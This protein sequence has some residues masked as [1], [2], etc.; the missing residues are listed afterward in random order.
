MDLNLPRGMR[1]FPPEEKIVR[2]RLT[3]QL[4]RVFELY[5]FVPL[6]TPV[7][8]R[9]DVL[10]AKYAGG[11]DSDVMKEVFKVSDQ[12]GRELGLRFDLTVPLARFVAMNPELKM[13]FKRYQIGKVYRDG[14]I[15]FGRY[16]EFW[17]YDVDIVGVKS[18]TADAEIVSLALEVFS[19]LGLDVVLKVNN[20]KLLTG[21]LLKAGVPDDLL[22]SAIIS[23]DKL[24]KI[25]VEGVS[26]ELT[27]K[28][29]SSEVVSSLISFLSPGNDLSFFES[30][31]PGNE[32]LLEL[33]E[34]FSLLPS[35]DRVV[36][37]PNLARGLAYY[38][39][40][41]FEV[42]LRDG[43]FSSSLAGGGRYDKMIG[44]YLDNK[45]EVPAVG[46]SFGFE[47]ILDLLKKLGKV[48]LDSSVTRVLLV[49]VG[50]FFKEA[51]S[52]TNDLRRAGVPS[53]VDLLGRGVSKN[54][55]YASAKN[56]PFV[57]FVGEDE[58]S[59][60]LFTLKELS[61][62]VEEK[63]SFEAVKKKLLNK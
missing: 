12:G 41:V 48:V 13:P 36:F 3:N 8:E 33:K 24:D 27:A 21:V 17:Q 6:E 26:E 14:P 32:G 4:I 2:Q 55:K 1:D 7:V 5:G 11:V 51:F 53:E 54:I 62:G 46:L 31:I 37:S 63:L 19:V 34:L 58:L 42:F 23:L 20:R 15:K 43:S 47:P 45:R 49:P 25:G 16:R 35:D 60:G 38:T 30:L 40:S 29:L 56:I 9:L 28:G 39:G 44:L 22:E 52:L 57:L 50:P 61:S 59:N 18:M 10:S